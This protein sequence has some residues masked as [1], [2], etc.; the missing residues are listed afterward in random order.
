LL[1]LSACGRPSSPS[2]SILNSSRTF[3]T[4]DEHST[5]VGRRGRCRRHPAQHDCHNIGVST[6]DILACA[7]DGCWEGGAVRTTSADQGSLQLVYDM[8]EHTGGTLP[9]RQI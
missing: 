4:R 8:S 6:C 5:S 2:Y 3:H 7:L 9:A 1:S